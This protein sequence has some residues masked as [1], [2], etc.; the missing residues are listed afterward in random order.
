MKGVETKGTFAEKKGNVWRNRRKQK[1]ERKQKCQ[2]K[3]WYK[4]FEE[5]KR[6]GGVRKDNLN[7]RCLGKQFSAK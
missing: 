7:L 2:S 4:T 1:V 3:E 6:I 5:A